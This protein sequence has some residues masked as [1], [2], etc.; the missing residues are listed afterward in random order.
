MKKS[1]DCRDLRVNYPCLKTRVFD[2]LKNLTEVL[3]PLRMEIFVAEGYDDGFERKKCT[4]DEM[5]KDLLS[6]IEKTSFID[7]CIYQIQ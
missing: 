3:N 7:S 6:Q 2:C 1:N 4:L 5:K